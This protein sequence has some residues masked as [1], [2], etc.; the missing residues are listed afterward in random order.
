MHLAGVLY[1]LNLIWHLVNLQTA[2]LGNNFSFFFL[3]SGM[4]TAGGDLAV[5]N[6]P[7]PSPLTPLQV[8]PVMHH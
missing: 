7:L 4:I 3:K 6:R 5:E 1:V 2:V 8:K